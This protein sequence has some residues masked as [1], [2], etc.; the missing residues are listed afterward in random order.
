MLA[1]EQIE[2]EECACGCGVEASVAH[3]KTIPM[4]TQPV[5]CYARRA[6]AIAQRDARQQSLPEKERDPK[7]IKGHAQHGDGVLWSVWPVTD[8]QP[9]T[10][11]GAQ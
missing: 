9:E 1:L 3:D 11:G 5:T 7:W 10:P 2:S 4:A 8:T 6:L